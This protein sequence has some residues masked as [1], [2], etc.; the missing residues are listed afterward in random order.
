MCLCLVTQLCPALCNPMD[1]SPP[2]ASIHS[3]F[4]QEYW[5]RL[6]FP[7]PGALPYPVTEPK[8]SVSS[9]LQ[10]D[11]LLTEPSGTPPYIVLYTYICIHMHIYTC[12]YMYIYMYMCMYTCIHIHMYIYMYMYVYVC[13][14]IHIHTYR[15]RQ[16]HTTNNLSHEILESRDKVCSLLTH[17]T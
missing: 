3:I 9:A 11:S 2:G 1:C 12:V 17:S 10:V 4:Q 13:V 16:T 6:P 14:Y 5:S 15:F 7:S 8:S